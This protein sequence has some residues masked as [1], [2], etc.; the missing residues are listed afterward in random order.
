MEAT[1]NGVMSILHKN[2]GR[3]PANALDP[4]LALNII[5]IYEKEL[6]N[7]NFCHA[8]DVLAED[9]G[10]FVSVST[11]SRHLK[12]SGI[13]S[14]KAKRRPKKHRSR[15]ARKREGELVQMDASS[16]DWLGNDSYLHL[17]GAVDDATGR[18]LALHFE[19][20]ETFEGYC[21]LMFQMNQDG[22]LPREIYTDGR[23]VFAYDSKTKKKLTLDEELTGKV[24]RQPHFARALRETK[25]LLIIAKSAQ[26]KGGIERLWETLQD[27]LPKDMKRKGINSIEQAN[28]FLRQYIPYYNRKF[29]V[30]A[31][32]MEKAYLPKQ[33]LAAFQ[34]TFAI[35]ETRKLDS[36]LSF[37]YR[38]Q[39]YRLPISKDNKEIPASPHDTITVATSKHIGMQVLFKGLVIK[40]EPL[41]TQ[42]KESIIHISQPDNSTNCLPSETLIKPKNKTNSPWFGYTEIFYSK[43]LRDDISAA[44]LSPYQGDII[45]DY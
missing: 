41:N 23:T 39:K 30:Q 13:R 34:L 29:S 35:H 44:Q 33:D 18:I 2:R 25:I 1:A 40:P 5:E 20:E 9:K 16:Y 31:A 10:I 21:E 37:S 4:K 36:G 8:T 27:R 19:K 7:Y 45:A 32:S 17:H 43:K 3:K 24:E 22:H 28:E 38:G 6:I 42:P 26:A 15:N 12:A 11:V 14:P